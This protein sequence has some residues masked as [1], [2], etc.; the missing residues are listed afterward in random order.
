LTLFDLHFLPYLKNIPPH[1]KDALDS[2]L[3]ADA[4]AWTR[5]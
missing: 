4:G 5:S 1:E 3:F 2:S